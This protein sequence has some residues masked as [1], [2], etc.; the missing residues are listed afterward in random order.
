MMPAELTMKQI[1]PFWNSV[2]VADT[3]VDEEQRT[4]GLILPIM[5]DYNQT[6]FHRGVVLETSGENFADADVLKPGMV[7]FFV[8]GVKIGDVWVVDT[9]DILAYEQ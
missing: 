7:V 8:D 4:S 6:P 1:R 3:L 2:T 5:G 9:T